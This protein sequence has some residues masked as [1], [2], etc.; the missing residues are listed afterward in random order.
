MQA[1]MRA[2]TATRL[3]VEHGVR[4]NGASAV[5]VRDPSTGAAVECLMTQYEPVVYDTLAGFLP[6]RGARL[7]EAG[8]FRGGSAA[9][10]WHGLRRRGSDAGAVL[11]CHD[12]FEPFA[13]GADT[14]DI[15]AEFDATVRAWGIGGAVKVKGDS[16]RTAAV[17]APGSL[18][19]VF[20]DGDHTYSG[21][22]GDL[23]AFA[24]A[25]R[26]AGWLVVQDCVG[27]VA[28]ALETFLEHDDDTWHRVEVTPPDGH[29]VSVCHRDRGALAAFRAAL[30]E[31]LDRARAGE[32]EAFSFGPA[33]R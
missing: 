27:E 29:F 23:R 10:A 6:Q 18:D 16:K 14:V 3:A 2:M 17:H 22:L 30:C 15:E 13:L 11:V 4:P 33:P 12:V 25:L 19:Y 8:S 24:P 20:V 1:T 32:H 7:A 5:T 28:A 21:A 9:V 31:A 26:P